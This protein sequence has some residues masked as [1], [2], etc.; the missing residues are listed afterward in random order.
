MYGKT[1]IWWLKSGGR[2][3]QETREIKLSEGYEYIK[4]LEEDGEVILHIDEQPDKIV[5]ELEDK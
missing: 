2:T 5:I 4:K 3:G 1:F